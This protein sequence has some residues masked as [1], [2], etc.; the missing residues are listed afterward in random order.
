MT[1][2]RAIDTGVLTFLKSTSEEGFSYTQARHINLRTAGVTR[3]NRAF[4]E[5]ASVPNETKW[6][7]EH[8][9]FVS[10]ELRIHSDTL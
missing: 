5:V 9:N 10:S 2:V 8:R 1:S 6:R 4:G 7:S 3:L